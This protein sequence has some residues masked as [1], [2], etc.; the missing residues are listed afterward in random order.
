MPAQ[1]SIGELLERAV[2][3]CPGR[4]R[5]IRTTPVDLHGNPTG[6]EA[7]ETPVLAGVHYYSVAERVDGTI[8]MREPLDQADSFSSLESCTQ[9]GNWIGSA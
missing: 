2:E 8:R 3:L 5:I 1:R 6:Q 7:E 9:Q 4:F